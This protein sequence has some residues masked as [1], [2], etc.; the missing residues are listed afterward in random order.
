MKN[1]NKIILS[2]VMVVF[3]LAGCGKQLDITNTFSSTDKSQSTLEKLI[4]YEI[5]E[6]NKAVDIELLKVELSNTNSF[7]GKAAIVFNRKYD[8][9]LINVK[10]AEIYQSSEQKSNLDDLKKLYKEIA[11]EYKSNIK[12]LPDAL[13]EGVEDINEILDDLNNYASAITSSNADIDTIVT[14]SQLFADR[15]SAVVT[16]LYSKSEDFLVDYPD[17]LTDIENVEAVKN[18]GIQD[19]ITKENKLKERLNKEA[20]KALQKTTLKE[21]ESGYKAILKGNK[22]VKFDKVDYNDKEV[23]AVITYKNITDLYP[24]III[25]TPKKLM[26]MDNTDESLVRDISRARLKYALNYMKSPI[27]SA[28]KDF[29]NEITYQVESLAIIKLEQVGKKITQ[30][31]TKNLT[32]ISRAYADEIYSLGA[33]YGDIILNTPLEQVKTNI[34][35]IITEALA[36]LDVIN[37]K[38]DAKTTEEITLLENS[39]KDYNNLSGKIIDDT[40]AVGFILDIVDQYYSDIDKYSDNPVTFEKSANEFNEI[41]MAYF[42]FNNPIPVEVRFTIDGKFINK[43]T[44]NDKIDSKDNYHINAQESGD[45][46][47]RINANVNESLVLMNI[48]AFS[49]TYYKYIALSILAILIVLFFVNKKAFKKMLT[50]II[51]LLISVIVLYPMAWIIGSS[52]S[53]HQ[54]LASVSINPIPKNPS[55]LQYKRLFLHESY[56]YK[57][58]YFNSFKIA[59]FNMLMCVLLTVSTAYVFSRFKFKGKK[60]GMMFMLIIQI[61]PSF[62]AMVAI[63]TLLSSI[64]FLK[65]L[66]G[67]QSLVDTHLGLLLVYSAGQVPYN[68]WLVKGYFDSISRSLDEAA[69]IDGASNLQAF[70]KVILPLGVPIVSFVAVTSFMAPWMDFILPKLLLKSPNKLTLAIGLQEMITGQANNNFTLFAAGA[71]LVAVPITALFSFMQKYVVTGLSSGAVKG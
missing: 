11:S 70:W 36:E 25:S 45:L 8:D 4:A 63:Y 58:W 40:E 47:V 15:I 26:S 2:M 10:I 60:S 54:A 69:K 17:V 59:V 9:A 44:Y 18:I 29:T 12:A 24:N 62:S 57:A 1:I 42:S 27:L 22:N 20:K 53:K 64:T 30:A 61:F 66:T 16:V 55:L 68:T 7:S 43:M 51:L 3:L 67:T 21:I 39:L 48:N 32:D 38:Y 65:P 52:F 19:I 56:D 23:F 41:T 28:M 71:V 5:S 35:S 50:I 13:V 49:M 34:D 46:T 31:S 14:D 37:A 6:A 33:K